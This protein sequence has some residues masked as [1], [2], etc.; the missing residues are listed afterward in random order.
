MLEGAAG[1]GHAGLIILL[2]EGT[3]A[4]IEHTS[5]FAVTAAAR[6]TSTDQRSAPALVLDG[7]HADMVTVLASMAIAGSP[8]AKETYA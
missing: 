1:G 3:A 5:M 8:N 6:T 2:R 7:I 4:W